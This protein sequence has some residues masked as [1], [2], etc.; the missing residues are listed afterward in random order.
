MPSA[1]DMRRLLHG[2]IDL[3][4]GIERPAYHPPARHP[5]PI[6]AGIGL[7]D[8]LGRLHLDTAQI[9][10]VEAQ[11]LHFGGDLKIVRLV[12]VSSEYV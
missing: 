1:S 5:V 12:G 2:G 8:G 11:R 3:C 6:P 4:L 9:E 10:V 7:G